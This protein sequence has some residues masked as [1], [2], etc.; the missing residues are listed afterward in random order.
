MI[1]MARPVAALPASSFFDEGSMAEPID[2][3]YCAVS[4]VNA[5]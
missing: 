5:R 2:R 4:F 3:A 1:R